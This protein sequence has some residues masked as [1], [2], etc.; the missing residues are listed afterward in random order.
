MI[1]AYPWT[2]PDHQQEAS[3]AWPRGSSLDFFLFLAAAF[4][5]VLTFGKRNDQS[6]EKSDSSGRLTP[7]VSRECQSTLSLLET[8]SHRESRFSACPPSVLVRS[9]ALA[10]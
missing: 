10:G 1:P 6:H 2:N 4:S 8:D 5:L 3:S 9:L 7:A